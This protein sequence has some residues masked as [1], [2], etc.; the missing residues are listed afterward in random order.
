MLPPRLDLKMPS[1]MPKKKPRKGGFYKAKQDFTVFSTNNKKTKIPEG[2]RILVTRGGKNIQ[3]TAKPEKRPLV[4][5]VVPLDFF[6]DNCVETGPIPDPSDIS[7]PYSLFQVKQLDNGGFSY[8][9]LEDGVVIGV[10]YCEEYNGIGIPDIKLD[11]VAS[12][13]CLSLKKKLKANREK[14]HSLKNF[15][16]FLYLG[17]SGFM[18]FDDFCR[19]P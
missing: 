16:Y 12:C 11:P 8:K 17:Y 4:N 18:T 1:V 2:S 13:S 5:A 3:F 9:L 10:V 15:L 6:L 14:R 19:K 7:K